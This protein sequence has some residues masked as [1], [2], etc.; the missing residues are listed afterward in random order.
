[1]RPFTPPRA[2]EVRSLLPAHVSEDQLRRLGELAAGAPRESWQHLL[3]PLKGCLCCRTA[4]EEEL[5]LGAEPAVE[6]S[7]EE[8]PRQHQGL[9]DEAAA[10]A[11]ALAKVTGQ[12]Q[13]WRE[14]AS[15]QRAAA[16]QVATELLQQPEA[17]WQSLIASD[18]RFR[19]PVLAR[20]LGQVSRVIGG[21]DEE[22]GRRA[23]VAAVAVASSL[24]A[25]EYTG[26]VVADALAAAYAALGNAERCGGDLE[27]AREAFRQ[28][29]RCLVDGTAIDLAVAEVEDLEALLLIEEQRYG[30]AL[31][32]LQRAATAYRAAGSR[33]QETRVEGLIGRL[34]IF[35]ARPELAIP[36]LREALSSVDR[37]RD[38][39]LGAWLSLQLVL[40]LAE[41]GQGEEAM[42]LLPQAREACLLLND[43]RALRS[44]RWTEGRVEGITAA[45]D[46]ARQGLLG[47]GEVYDAALAT[48]DL[49][50]L[51]LREGRAARAQMLAN[52]LHSLLEEAD[53][54][55]EAKATLAVFQHSLRAGLAT[56]TSVQQLADY[57]RRARSAGVPENFSLP[58]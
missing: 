12:L 51:Y 7:P 8:T 57:L 34:L 6:A 26:G 27:A 36:R 16:P 32:R 14:R 58:C 37:E 52:G 1:M 19:S 21:A 41:A 3:Q 54:G 31:D 53:L 2:P 35:A 29:R 11:A 9:V 15:R 45:V 10:T 46:E 39:H 49:A 56:E 50:S 30:E 25:E 18:S 4:V 33:L 13:Y 22:Q 24:E 47:A 20:V 17:E 38:L 28:A 40:A 42:R 48:L 44:L 23:A 5:W 55:I 43:Q